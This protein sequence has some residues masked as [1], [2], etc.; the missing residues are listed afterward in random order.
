[1]TVRPLDIEAFEDPEQLREAI[2][3]KE[4]QMHSVELEDLDKYRDYYNGEQS[5]V[6]GTKK[7]K[8]RFGDAFPGFRDNWTR[9]VVDAVGDKTMLQGIHL[10]DKH[11]QSD[12][13]KTISRDLWDYFRAND[14]DEFQGNIHS[15]AY[16]E[17]RST[18]II[19]PDEEKG[20][21]LDWNPAQLVRVT[22]QQTNRS[23]PRWAVK[24]WITETEDILVTF[25][26]PE[27]IYKYIERKGQG[28]TQTSEQRMTRFQEVPTTGPTGGMLERR[29][30]GDEPWP[31]PNPFDRVPVVEF[32]NIDSRSELVDVVPQQDAVNYILRAQLLAAEFAAFGQRVMV[33][34]QDMPEGGWLSD[35]GTV[36]QLKPIP[37]PD[38][39][40]TIPQFGTFDVFD[41]STYNKIV[42]QYL[43]HMAFTTKTP[44]SY[45]F[46]SDRGGRGD[47]PSGE[48]LKVENKPLDDKVL[49]R[50]RILGN[51]W[52]RAI[53][54]V[55]HVTEGHPDFTDVPLGEPVWV[56]PRAEYRMALLEEALKMIETGLPRKWT[57][58]RL[59]LT[60]AEIEEAEKELAEQ[61][62]DD[63][64]KAEQQ[65][66]MQAEVVAAN[67]PKS[68]SGSTGVQ[69][70][71]S[72]A[73]V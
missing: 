66:E 1:M 9:V 32:A 69:G 30:V 56:D 20:V 57:W 42:E 4:L 70:S 33:T 29:D 43:Q 55:S 3:R 58:K 15:G 64:K 25:Y 47:A 65:A 11:N 52:Y 36:W 49:K 5:L 50:Q 6:Y 19:W 54:L 16:V 28:P 51:R 8:D 40:I 13:D 31:L 39:S 46:E 63:L 72:R 2:I 37:N 35:P 34:S 68:D 53:K 24:R 26:T 7:F 18:L 59:G 41:P 14:V 44:V 48:S 71:G 27:F 22:Y 60:Q 17:G 23:E 62:V 61:E 73:K 45:F 38:G 67:Q 21:T 10:G 12:D